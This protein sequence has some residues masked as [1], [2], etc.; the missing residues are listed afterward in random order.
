MKSE[1]ISSKHNLYWSI[2][3]IDEFNLLLSFYAMWNCLSPSLVANMNY[4]TFIIIILLLYLK[5]KIPPSPFLFITAK[6]PYECG[7]PNRFS[8]G[9]E[10]IMYASLR[11]I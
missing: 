10:D 6:E 3:V 2:R 8:Y 4:Y 5:K 1:R 11:N 7:F 9:E